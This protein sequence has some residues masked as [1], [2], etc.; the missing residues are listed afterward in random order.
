MRECDIL[1]T[2]GNGL[3]Q[4]VPGSP[5]WLDNSINTKTMIVGIG[6]DI[7]NV[8]RLEDELRADGKQLRES[9]FTP[10]EISYCESKHNPAEHYAAR[11]AAKEAL[12]KALAMDGQG[13]FVWREAEVTNDDSG[14]PHMHLY[15]ALLNRSRQLSVQTIFVTLSHTRELATASVIL[16][17]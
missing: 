7:F 1:I 3:P 11:F 6:N 15:G 14:Q 5:K 4:S 2:K 8:A 12:L 9:I 10:R 17:S 13:G 16:E